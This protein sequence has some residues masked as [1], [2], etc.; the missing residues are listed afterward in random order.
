MPGKLRSSR[1]STSSQSSYSPKSPK[2][3]KSRS[4]RRV[5]AVAGLVGLALIAAACS[6]PPS[7]TAGKKSTETTLEPIS[8]VGTQDTTPTTAAAATPQQQA[9][10]AAAAKKTSQTT[11]PARRVVTGGQQGLSGGGDDDQARAVG[12]R[13]HPQSTERKQPYYLGVGEDTIQLDFSYD[14]T[15]CGVNVVNAITAAGGALPS[16]TR[17]YRAAPNSQDGVVADTKES[18]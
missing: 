1:M 13:L 6:K 15:S 7:L 17:F 4:N 10:A 2:S 18:I 8:P 12:A 9:V 16:P 3:S 5:P 11:A 14:Q